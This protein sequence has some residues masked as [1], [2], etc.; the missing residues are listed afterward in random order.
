MKF[1]IVIPTFNRRS[2]LIATIDSLLAQD[3]QDL[4]IL[5]VD[6]GPSTDGTSEVVKSYETKDSRIKYIPTDVKGLVPARNRGLKLATGE[7]YLTTDDD[8]ELLRKDILTDVAKLFTENPD[9]GVVGSIEVKNPDQ[10]LEVKDRVPA[11]T[12]R[13]KVTGE[14]DSGFARAVGHGITEVDHVRTAFMAARKEL[15]DQVGGFDE[16]YLAMGIGFRYESDLCLKIQHLGYKIV[17]DPAI[18]IWHKAVARPRGFKRGR[19]TGYFFYANRNHAFF[20]RR[21]YWRGK[22]VVYVFYDIFV[23]AKVTPG[24]WWSLRLAWQE[25]NLERLAMLPICI[26]GKIWGNIKY[27]LE[28]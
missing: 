15:M 14:F 11:K 24:M 13:I 19:G 12:G 27:Q 20:M 16:T 8:I 26:A 6:N 3:Y 28:G 10:E 9:V 4:E 1:S 21:F 18:V 7:I 5:I 22:K 25:R 23:G 17:V 2:D